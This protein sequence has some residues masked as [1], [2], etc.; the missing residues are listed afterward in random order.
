MTTKTTRTRTTT[1]AT[2]S[3]KT[4]PAKASIVRTLTTTAAYPVAFTVSILSH[5]KLLLNGADSQ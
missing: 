1:R 4:T 2:I 5:S 3:S